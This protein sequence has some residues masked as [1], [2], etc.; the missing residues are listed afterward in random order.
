MWDHVIKNGTLVTS[1]EIFSGNIYIKDGKIAAISDEILYDTD[2]ASNKDF[3]SDGANIPGKD[4]AAEITDASGK[5][6]L[7]GFIDTHVHS[8]D[9]RKGL[10]HKEDFFTSSMAGAC[11]GITTIFEMPNCNPATY[12]KENL[13]DLVEVIGP[14]AHT[15]YG[16]W[17]ICLGELNNSEISKLDEAGAIAFKYFWGYAIDKETYQLVYNYEEGMEG[18][19]P[20]LDDGEVY[21]IFKEVAKTG[22]VVAIHAE[23]FYVI[24]AMTNAVKAEARK[25]AWEKYQNKENLN[26]DDDKLPEGE[27]YSDYLSYKDMLRGRPGMAETMVV[28]SAIR[29]AELTGARLHILHLSNGDNVKLIRDAQERGVPITVETCHQYLSL[30]D[31]EI[32]EL[33][34]VAKTLPLVRTKDD[35]EKLWAG[36]ADGTISHITSDHAPHTV[37]EKSL[38]IW[39]APGGIVGIETMA[40]VLID[41]VNKGRITINDLARL[42]GEGPAKTFDI[43]PEKGSLE[44]GT[45]AD[46]TIVD[47]EPEYVFHQE[48][49]HSKTKLSPLDGRSFKGRVSKTILR[50]RTIAENGEIVGEP[51]GHF[52]KK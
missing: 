1:S 51:S 28:E 20:P 21:K 50:G 5:Y 46:I 29:I 13:E 15:D 11:G 36:L 10:H 40:M 49:L 27:V 24:R 7:P 19:I 38:G 25:R 18:I 48:S 8:R 17:A 12:N 9:G 44:V 34:A 32:E 45:D 2:A 33:G 23:N 4:F 43:Y 3:S 22:K 31:D 14:K 41:G 30:C 47:L 35:Q 6:V 39:E 37:E 16:I 26:C 42:L 52:L